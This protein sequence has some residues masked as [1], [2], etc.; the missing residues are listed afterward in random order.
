MNETPAHTGAHTSG[1]HRTAA[2]G[3]GAGASAGAA[4]GRSWW[5]GRSG[6]VLALIMAA[7]GTYM[8]Y[9][10]L[11]MQVAEDAD[12]PGPQFVPMVI[13]IASYL[14]AAL[15]TIAYIRTPEAPVEA[16]GAVAGGAS[17]DPDDIAAARGRYRTFSDY[18]SLAWAIGGFAGF[19]LLLEPLGWILAAAGLYWCVTRAMGS[20]K[21]LFDATV[22]LTV[23]S[24]IY[25]ALGV[26][27]GLNLPSG[28]LGGL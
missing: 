21:P 1:A 13:A 6:L 28:I 17:A 27:L 22:A 12:K 4:G 3:G 9:G 11:T 2:A 14:L 16:G 5:T 20:T 8:L 19:V 24:I 10:V 18:A 23:S 7:F 26:S 25:L 15:L